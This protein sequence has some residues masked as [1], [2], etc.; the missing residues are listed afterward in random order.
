MPRG[1]CHRGNLNAGVAGK[2]GIVDFATGLVA[3]GYELLATDGTAKILRVD[4]V[5]VRNVADYTGH[6]EVLGG[7]G[8]TLHPKIFAAILAPEG[9]AE[10]VG[11]GGGGAR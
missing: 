4:R 1:P 9:G 8:K 11:G 3:L 5:P 2:G 6:P 7:R 10:G